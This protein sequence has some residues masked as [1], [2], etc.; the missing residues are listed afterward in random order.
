MIRTEPRLS[1]F[2]SFSALLLVGCPTEEVPIDTGESASETNAGDGDG[3]TGDGDGDTGDG[4]GDGDSGDGDGDGDLCGNGDVDPGEACDDSNTVEGD[5]CSATCQV[6]SCG[7]VWSQSMDTPNSNVGAFDVEIG[8]D[9]SIYGAGMMIGTDNDGWAAKWNP[10]GTIA[11]SQTFDGGMGNDY[12]NGIA[13]GAGGEVY[14]AG[15][16]AGAGDDLWYAELSNADGSLTWEQV[17]PGDMMV[18]DG[19]DFATDID[20]ASTGELVI[21][22]RTRVADGDDDVWVRKAD[23]ADGTEIWTSTWTGMGDGMFSTDRSGQVSVADDGTVWASAREHVDFD[24][25]EATILQFDADGNFVSLIQPQPAGNHSHN[26]VDIQAAA[27]GTIYFAMD[28]SDFPYHGWLYKLMPDGTEVWV[29]TEA[30]WLIQADM[31]E[32]GSDWSVR[33]LGVDADGNLGV[34]GSF[35][36]EEEGQGIT[37]NEAWTAKLDAAGE[38]ICRSH[39]KVD[40]GASLPPSLGI[41]TSGY[42]STGFGLLGVQTSN[43]GNMTKAWAGFFMP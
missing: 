19:D 18:M 28:K 5:G 13:L 14:V 9:G 39:L 10:D 36:N 22:G 35:G 34:G 4:D 1:F 3:D 38:Y 43:Q 17:V 33:G 24:S 31:M 7:L 25:Q 2:L 42:T 37:W 16:Q 41:Y 12:F 21:V 15:G 40:D 23:A 26:P 6:T 8:D 11:W 27:D 32:L 20:V 29:K 30:D